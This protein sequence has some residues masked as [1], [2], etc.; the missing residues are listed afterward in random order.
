M[1]LPAI[2]HGRA[3]GAV[4]QQQAVGSLNLEKRKAGIPTERLVALVDNR[5]GNAQLSVRVSED[6]DG[7][8]WQRRLRAGVEDPRLREWLPKFED[9]QVSRRRDSRSRIAAFAVADRVEIRQAHL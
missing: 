9:R 2:E 6:H 1:P 3:R 8:G 7:L 4:V 5:A